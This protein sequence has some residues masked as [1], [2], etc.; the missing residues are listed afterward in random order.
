MK[1]KKIKEDLRFKVEVYM[2]GNTKEQKKCKYYS[3]SNWSELCRWFNMKDFRCHW[4]NNE[5]DN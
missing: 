3:E 5:S 4:D 2:C 1:S